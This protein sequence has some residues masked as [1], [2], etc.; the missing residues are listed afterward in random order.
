M[1]NQALERR[2]IAWAEE[3]VRKQP[4][5]QED[6]WDREGNKIVS[7]IESNTV[8]HE[9]ASLL[10]QH[11]YLSN[12]DLS[13]RELAEVV[14]DLL[15]DGCQGYYSMTRNELLAA[16]EDALTD[17]CYDE[18]PALAGKDRLTDEELADQFIKSITEEA[19]C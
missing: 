8:E 11:V 19:E 2:L 10:G 12:A 16:I 7:S 17:F 5:S 4:T 14:R 6:R 1:K 13:S 15:L 18:A 9:L 3:Q